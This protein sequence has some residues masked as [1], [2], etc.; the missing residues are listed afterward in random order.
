MKPFSASPVPTPACVEVIGHTTH[1]ASAPIPALSTNESVTRLRTGRPQSRA[2]SPFDAQ[3]RI[4]RPSSV[5]RKKSPS[6]TTIAAQVASVHTTCG[7]TRAPATSS[8]VT[9]SPVK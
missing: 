8:A 7:E 4:W 5:R 1:P 3:A 6:R 2:A 9:S